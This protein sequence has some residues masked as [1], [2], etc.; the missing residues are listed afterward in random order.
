MVYGVSVNVWFVLFFT[1]NIQ[2]H[3]LVMFHVVTDLG[4]SPHSVALMTQA[5]GV[6]ET[7]KEKED[8]VFLL[9]IVQFV[10]FPVKRQPFSGNPSLV[11]GG[12]PS[13]CPCP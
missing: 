8:G 3:K 11:S 9:F 2:F 5:E 7:P 12:E 1:V 6:P 13:G 4:M 10:R